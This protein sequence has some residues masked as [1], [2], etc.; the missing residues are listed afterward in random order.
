MLS[1][2]KLTMTHK[3]CLLIPVVHVKK[4]YRF[5]P[6]PKGNIDKIFSSSFRV[7]VKTKNFTKNFTKN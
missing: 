7:E 3:K 4:F 1:Y 5:F 6:N 2:I